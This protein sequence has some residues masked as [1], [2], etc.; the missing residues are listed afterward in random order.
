MA[1]AMTVK[2]A[3]E[4][5]RVSADMIYRM[6]Y[7]G[8]LPHNRTLGRGRNGKG[9][10]RIPRSAIEDWLQGGERVDRSGETGKVFR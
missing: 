4:E 1:L 9:R 3:A 6:C 8:E 5:L 10:I 2:E 7:V